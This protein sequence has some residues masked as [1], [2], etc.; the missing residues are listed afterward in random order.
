MVIK[1]KNSSKTKKQNSQEKKKNSSKKKKFK[2][3]AAGDLHGDVRQAKK[4]AEIADK[5]KVDLVILTGDLIENDLE[6]GYMI[7]P[8]LNR[9]KKILFIPGNHESFAT[10][11]FLSELYGP[12][13]KNLH[14][15]SMKSKDKKFG[16]FGVGGANIG[17]HA[18]SEEEIF[19]NLKKSFRDV[20]NLKKKIMVSHVHPSG[21]KIEKFTRF[22]PGSEG[23]RK[24]IKEFQP[25]IAIC[26]HVHEAEGIEEKIG[27]TRLINVGRHGKIIEI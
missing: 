18:L 16:V 17:I 21:T 11:D 15:Y 4:L 26:S 8:F 9:K 14:S 22:F 12:Y 3:L 27:K 23:V 24:A 7:G 20:K 5:E 10:A 6:T 13:A 25:D 19:D 1:K 2:I